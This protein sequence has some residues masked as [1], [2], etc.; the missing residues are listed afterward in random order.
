MSVDRRSEPSRWT[1]RSVLGSRR[2]RSGVRSSASVAFQVADALVDVGVDRVVRAVRLPASNER[3]AHVLHVVVADGVGEDGQQVL[4]ARCATAASAPGRRRTGASGGRG[5]V[6]SGRGSRC[7]R[8]CPRGSPCSRFHC[9]IDDGVVLAFQQHVHR[10]A[11]ELGGVEAVEQ[12]R[13]AAALRVADLT[14]ED[15]GLGRSR[16]AGTSGSTRRRGA[17]SGSG[18]A[19]RRRRSGPRCRPGRATAG[20]AAQ[21]LAVLVDDPLAADDH[22]VLLQLVDLARPA[23]PARSTFSGCSGTSMMSGWP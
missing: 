14:G 22:H 3:L 13:P 6:P 8:S 7:R 15:R 1:W 12:D 18:A 5:S 23:R 10:L 20:C 17:R 19:P 2:M 11:A 16:R 4:D 9:R 21:L